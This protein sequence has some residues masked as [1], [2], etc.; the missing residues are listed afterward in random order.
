VTGVEPPT[1]LM[2]GAVPPPYHGSNVLFDSLLASPLKDR[3]RLVHVDLSDPRDLSNLGR[4]D[5]QNVRIG[6]A[7]VA[8]CYRALRRERPAIVYVGVAMNTF[9]F[10]RDSLF[11]R[12][13]RRFGAPR[14]RCVIH[15][16]GGYFG[17]F[18]RRAS[19]PF[20]RY[21]RQTLRDVDAAIVEADAL[22]P[23]L[24]GLVPDNR[25]WTVPNGTAGMPEELRRNRSNQSRPTVVYLSNLVKTKGFLD[26]MAAA[27]LVGR[28]VADVRFVLAGSYHTENDRRE[29]QKTLS[30]PAV[31]ERVELPGFVVGKAKYELLESAD[32]FVLPSYYPVEG[33]PTVLIEA[34]S[35]GLPVVTTDQGGIRETIVDGETGFIVP[36]RDPAAIASRVSEL[37][38]DEELRARMGRAAR[39]RFEERFQLDSYGLGVARVFEHVLAAPAGAAEAQRSA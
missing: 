15:I 33:Q 19:A 31:A 34:M 27:P 13:S 28:D 16:H 6:A 22:R 17:E 18:Y 2:I 8:A 25:I 39:R 7:N 37:L 24:A 10:F 14:P 5:V 36:K 26:V 29:A 38:R 12:L 3:F 35:A 32:V 30:D 11:I 9:A 4:L 23:T 1:A 20:H 21:I